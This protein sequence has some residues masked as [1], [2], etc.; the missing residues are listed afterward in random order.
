MRDAGILSSEE[1]EAKK[2]IISSALKECSK[3]IYEISSLFDHTIP[4]GLHQVGIPTTCSMGSCAAGDD[5]ATV[6]SLLH[7]GG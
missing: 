6:R 4:I 3:A 1:F 7:R 2:K 5:I